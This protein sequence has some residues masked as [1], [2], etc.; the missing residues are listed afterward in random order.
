MQMVDGIRRF[1][2]RETAAAAAKRGA[3]DRGA[4]A[5][6]LGVVDEQVP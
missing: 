1:L 5:Q 6:I 4:T 2:D 3:V